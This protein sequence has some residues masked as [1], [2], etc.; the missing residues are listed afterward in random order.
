MYSKVEFYS[1]INR[2]KIIK[3]SCQRMELET[4]ILREAAV[5]SL[6]LAQIQNLAYIYYICKFSKHG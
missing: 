6:V 5:H 1:N 4:I 2:N 3:F